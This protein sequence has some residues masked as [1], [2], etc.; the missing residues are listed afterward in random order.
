MSKLS[1]ITITRN[2]Y[3]QLVETIDSLKLIPDYDLVVVNGGECQ[4]TKNFLMEKGIEHISEPDKGISDAFNKGI[5]KVFNKDSVYVIF[6]NSGDCIYNASYIT[7]AV[8]FLESNDSFSF[9]FGDVI[10]QDSLAG[11][12]YIPARTRWNLEEGCLVL[13]RRSFIARVF[14]SRWVCLMIR[15]DAPWIF[16]IFCG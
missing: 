16:S 6:I 2:N 7:K 3:D 4:K 13:I 12:L 14:L 10:Y 8:E 11:E 9:T 15:I 5:R 1:V